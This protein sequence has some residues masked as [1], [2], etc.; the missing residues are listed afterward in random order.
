[1]SE[2]KE[3]EGSGGPAIELRAIND[4]I[5]E[6]RIRIIRIQGVS[7]QNRPRVQYSHGTAFLINGPVP[8]SSS[9]VALTSVMQIARGRKTRRET[10][11][12]YGSTHGR[13]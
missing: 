13:V 1:V 11:V 7:D 8:F 2:G 5:S 3:P 4:R 12:R 6:Q 10:R 9:G